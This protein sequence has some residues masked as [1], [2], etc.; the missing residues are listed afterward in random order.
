[1]T[2]NEKQGTGRQPTGCRPAGKRAPS[3]YARTLR[4][5]DAADLDAALATG[6]QDEIAMIRIAMRRVL[7]QAHTAEDVRLDDWVEVLGA[8]GSAATRLA[9]LLKTEHSL[10]AEPEGLSGALSQALNEV[11]KEMKR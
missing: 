10:S 1:M 7:E 6:L 2:P 8:L 9:T 4:P 11:L 3:F 5:V